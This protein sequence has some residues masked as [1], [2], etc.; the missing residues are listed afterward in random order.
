MLPI[1]ELIQNR[2][3]RTFQPGESVIREGESTG[4]LYFLIAGSVEVLK[5]ST[6]VAKSSEPG[7]VFGELAALLGGHHTATVRAVTACSVFVVDDAR[8]FM[9]G[10]PLICLH[11]C[12]LLAQRLDSLNKYLLDV[13]RQYEGHDHLGMVDNVLDTILHRHPRKR[14]KPQRSIDSERL[15]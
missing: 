4:N 14:A 8:E 15:D 3:V 12:E 6:F 5:G 9:K 7:A 10:S 2:E 13:K 1:L 11:V